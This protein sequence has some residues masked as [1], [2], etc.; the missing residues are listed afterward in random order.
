MNS[1]TFQLNVMMNY[2]RNAANVFV[3]SGK[4]MQIVDEKLVRNISYNK[5]RNTQFRKVSGIY[6]K[7]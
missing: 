4:I 3:P 6:L 7:A 5:F 1:F 2:L